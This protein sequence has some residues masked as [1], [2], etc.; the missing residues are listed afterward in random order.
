MQDGMAWNDLYKT[1]FD[2]KE[3]VQ[4][5]LLGWGPQRIV[6]VLDLSL[7]SIEPADTDFVTSH[8]FRK[9]TDRLYRVRRKDGGESY[10]AFHEN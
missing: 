2:Y 8:G 5:L 9:N 4:Q 3:V 1:L 7:D 10:C 6:Q